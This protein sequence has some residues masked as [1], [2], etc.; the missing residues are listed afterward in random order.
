MALIG[1]SGRPVTIAARRDV[2]AVPVVTGTT[3]YGCG[4]SDV[5][6]EV[7]WRVMLVMHLIAS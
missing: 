5:S 7:T 1:H 4:S 2:K 3:P 6:I